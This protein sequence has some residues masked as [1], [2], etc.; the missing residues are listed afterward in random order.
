MYTKNF[1]LLD[2]GPAPA[3]TNMELDAQLLAELGEVPV[4]HLYDWVGLA[5][6]YGH[7][8]DPKRHLKGDLID[9]ARRSTGGGIVFHI[10]DLAF[11]L[12]MPGGH[13][14]CSSTTLDNYLFVNRIVLSAVEELFDLQ[15]SLTPNDTVPQGPNCASF[16]M[17]R[18][19]IYDAVH[20]GLKVAGAAQR[21][22]RRG[23]LHQGTISLA[24]PDQKL[25]EQVLVNHDEIAA[26]MAEYT[27][28]PLGEASTTALHE[29]RRALKEK[30]AQKF[31][32]ALE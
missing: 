31:A 16:C 25:L 29:A 5:A 2:T 9:A 4:L 28:A 1:T 15:G 7:F 14:L 12:L 13:A 23:Y 26:A 27:F 30:L 21:R 24:L 3:A 20:N 22:T 10:W 17:A 19:T 6:T 32:L 18:P 8:I 11:S